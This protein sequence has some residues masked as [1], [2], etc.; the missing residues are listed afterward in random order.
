M[1]WIVKM[2][3]KGRIVIPRDVRDKF[4]LKKGDALQLEIRGNE[5]MIT[6]LSTEATGRVNEQE[7]NEFLS[8]Q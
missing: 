8:K 5:M 1:G 2:D 6:K 7:L 4:G 3:E